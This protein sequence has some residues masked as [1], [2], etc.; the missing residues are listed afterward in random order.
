MDE[1]KVGCMREK[2]GRSLAYSPPK[3]VDVSALKN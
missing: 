1:W 2:M 3:E